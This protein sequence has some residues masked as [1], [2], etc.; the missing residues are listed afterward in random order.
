MDWKEFF[1]PNFKKIFLCVVIFLILPIPFPGRNCK[2]KYEGLVSPAGEC[3]HYNYYI[4]FEYGYEFLLDNTPIVNDTILI[5]SN[6]GIIIISYI[7]SCLFFFLYNK[8]K[9]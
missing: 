3:P 1:K 6:I 9:K 2:I 4:N 7:I 8:I 5:F